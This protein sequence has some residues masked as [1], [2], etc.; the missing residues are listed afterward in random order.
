[1]TIP[2]LV[3]G[4]H[5]DGLR[6]KRSRAL[7]IISST[8]GFSATCLPSPATANVTSSPSNQQSFM[9]TS[10]QSHRVGRGPRASMCPHE[11]KQSRTTGLFG[12]PRASTANSTRS[13]SVTPPRFRSPMDWTTRGRPAPGA[14]RSR[15]LPLSSRHSRAFPPQIL[16]IHARACA[17][18]PAP[19]PRASRAPCGAC[20]ESHS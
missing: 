7:S 8:P 17:P 16:L 6:S 5:S 14:C 2:T 18:A 20:R 1:M 3:H 13:A 19:A 11:Y 9:P 12:S 10:R 15:L 4:M